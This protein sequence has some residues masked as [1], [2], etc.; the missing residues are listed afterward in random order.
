MVEEVEAEAVGGDAE[1]VGGVYGG[2]VAVGVC[3]SFAGG[4]ALA[5]VVG[6]SVV[7]DGFGGGAPLL[8]GGGVGGGEVFGECQGFEGGDVE[9]G[10]CLMFNV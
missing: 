7:G 5:A 10:G 2:L 4:V 1:V 3:F 8:H 9:H 6:F